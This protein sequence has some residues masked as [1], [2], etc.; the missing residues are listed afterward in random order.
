M[1]KYDAGLIGAGSMGGALATAVRGC[2]VDSEVEEIYRNSF[3]G[4]YLDPMVYLDRETAVGA[5]RDTS[6]EQEILCNA[7]RQSV[8]GQKDIDT[9]LRNAQREI[10]ALSS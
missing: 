9:A 4:A 6:R 7:F 2:G 3:Y 1:A 5:Y 10:E 8:T